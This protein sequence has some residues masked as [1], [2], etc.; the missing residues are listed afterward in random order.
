MMDA[1]EKEIYRYLK[2]QPGVFVT[3]NVICRHAAGKSRFQESSDWARAVL[4]RMNER[5]IVETDHS[6]AYRLK[7]VPADLGGAPQW[8]SPQIAELL[9]RSGKKIPGAGRQCDDDESYYDSL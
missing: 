7:P 6:G 9:L 5:S 8:V 2:S 1:D 3:M 4:M